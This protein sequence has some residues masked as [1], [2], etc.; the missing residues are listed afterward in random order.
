MMRYGAPGAPRSRPVSQC[1]API[2]VSS[3]DSVPGPTSVSFV[4]RDPTATESTAR[5]GLVVDRRIRHLD[6]MGIRQGDV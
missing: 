3:P 4:S 5:P 1:A 2:A 6:V